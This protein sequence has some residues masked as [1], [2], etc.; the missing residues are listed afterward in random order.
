MSLQLINQ[1]SSIQF[2]FLQ[3]QLPK[4]IEF[5]RKFY[6]KS[7][8]SP[9][10]YPLRTWMRSVLYFRGV[11]SQRRTWSA[12]RTLP[13]SRYSRY[14]CCSSKNFILWHDRK[15]QSGE[16]GWLKFQKTFEPK[17]NS[18]NHST[19]PFRNT[20]ICNVSLL[21]YSFCWVFNNIAAIK[22][23]MNFIPALWGSKYLPTSFLRS[24][25]QLVSFS[26]WLPFQSPFFKPWIR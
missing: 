13:S 17:Q 21:N 15:Q 4:A 11:S 12:S 14:F 20:A 8:Q 25:L 1:Q 18:R 23:S 24:P 2:E 7:S 6:W 3:C 5:L 16:K 10:T 22:L 19:M 26:Y 9:N